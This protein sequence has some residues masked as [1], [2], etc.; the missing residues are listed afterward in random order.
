MGSEI[1]AEDRTD[2]GGPAEGKG[3]DSE[4]SPAHAT[5]RRSG[6]A[7]AAAMQQNG[8]WRRECHVEPHCNRAVREQ[9]PACQLGFLGTAAESLEGCPHPGV[10]PLASR[11]PSGASGSTPR[12]QHGARPG[13]QGLVIFKPEQSCWIWPR[14][15]RHPL[16]KLA[17]CASG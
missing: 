5:T 9:R 3:G 1:G 16:L 15:K 13:G 17:P 8:T 12:A 7:G 11:Q 14:R 2:A 10:P 4:A 6:A